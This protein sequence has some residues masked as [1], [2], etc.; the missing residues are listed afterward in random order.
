MENSKFKLDNGLLI[1]VNYNQ[2]L[3]I[4][5]L[6]CRC[7]QHFPKA[8]TV[9]VDDGSTDG[10]GQL[11]ASLGFHV[12]EHPENTGIGSAIRSGIDHA[13]TNGYKWV[14]ICSSNGKIRPEEFS[15]VYKPLLSGNSDY[16]SGSRYLSGGSSPGLPLFRRLMIPVFSILVFPML[17]K[18]FTDI[19]CGFRAYS[20]DFIKQ[21]QCDI[22]QEWLNRY[23]LEYYLHYKACHAGLRMKEVPVTIP[24]DHLQKGRKSK[25]IPVVGWW[26]MIRPFVYLALRIRR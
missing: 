5:S 13:L 23:E 26:S 2:Y 24:Y 18:R 4:E 8:Q 16:I 21:V 10:S 6:L 20:L 19:T 22:H 17:G 12:I 25:I 1:V 3:E 9:V 11:A 14:M 15:V 7:E